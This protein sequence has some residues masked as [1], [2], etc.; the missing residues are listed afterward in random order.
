MKL[1]QTAAL[2]LSIALFSQGARGAETI[3][4]KELPTFDQ[5]PVPP[6]DIYDGIPTPVDLSSYKHADNYRTKLGEGAK[7][8]PN[9]AGHYTVV[10]IGAGTQFQDNWVIDAQSG[11]IVAKFLSSIIPQYHIDS[12]LLIINPADAIL[13]KGYRDHPNQPVLGALET[14]FETWN[15]K[16]QKFDVVHLHGVLALVVQK[17]ARGG[18]QDL[19][20]LF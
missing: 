14:T 17:A 20:A 11:K 7:K 10:T 18:H 12:T 2:A 3:S 6:A 5:Y 13:A 9:F 4:A 15:E 16:D 1:L 19:R 8:G